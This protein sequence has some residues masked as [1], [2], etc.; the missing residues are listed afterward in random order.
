MKIVAAVA[1]LS[2]LAGCGKPDSRICGSLPVALPH[3]PTT[4]DDYNQV[5]T[6]CV[7]RWAAR[8]AASDASASEI[9]RASIDPCS[10]TLAFYRD[11]IVNEQRMQPGD[12][13]PEVGTT[14]YWERR[15]LF[16]AIQ[17][18]AGGCYPSA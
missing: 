4:M 1:I 17:T 8:L 5:M 12:A 3:K 9:S 18:R 10:T 13:L 11:A 16:I 15:A 14:P 7:E 6:Y 2:L